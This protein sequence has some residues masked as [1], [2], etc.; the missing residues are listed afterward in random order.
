MIII[1]MEVQGNTEDGQ[2]KQE[3]KIQP[4]SYVLR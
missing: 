1:F 3:W 4:K 2:G